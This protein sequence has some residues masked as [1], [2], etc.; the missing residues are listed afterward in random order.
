MIPLTIS[1]AGLLS[2]LIGLGFMCP[3][4]ARAHW[5]ALAVF[6]GM[7]LIVVGSSIT[8]DGEL[9]RPPGDDWPEQVVIDQRTGLATWNDEP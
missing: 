6:V 8:P 4:N 2:L 3:D 7:I 5:G 1:C 9:K